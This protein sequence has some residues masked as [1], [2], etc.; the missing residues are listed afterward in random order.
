MPKKI[1]M[2]DTL[3]NLLQSWNPDLY[4]EDFGHPEIDR[5][6]VRSD[7][8]ERAD[9]YFCAVPKG[10]VEKP[11]ERMIA[12]KRDGSG[13]RT[14]EGVEHRSITNLVNKLATHKLVDIEEC[15]EYFASLDFELDEKNIF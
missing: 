14:S 12:F 2:F 1:Y 3:E 13:P 7:N 15:K 11:W 5:V 9:S 8:E 10:G 4:I 6:M